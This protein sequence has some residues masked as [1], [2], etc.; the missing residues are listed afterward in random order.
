MSQINTNAID[1]DYPIPGQNNNS[2]GF[3]TNFTNIKTN[4]DTAGNEITDLQNKAVLKA[5]L[6]NLPLNNDMANTL[7]SNASVRS[8]RATTFNLG[9][10]ISGTVR[11][12][13]SLGDVQ[14]GTIVGNTTFNFG[15]WAPSGTEQKITLTINAANSNVAGNSIITF[16]PNVIYNN[17]NY[18]LTLVENFSST[19]NI[20]FPNDV[21]QLNFELR[22]TD[23][24]NTIYITPLNRSY[25]ASQLIQRTPPPTGQPGDTAGTV[26]FDANYVYVCTD[27]YNSI[28]NTVYIL[29]TYSSSNKV[30]IDNTTKVTSNDPIILSAN[31][32]G[33]VANTIYYVVGI[34]DP[35]APGNISVSATRTGGVAGANVA[36]STASGNIV[37]ISYNGTDI[38]KRISLTTW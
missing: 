17:N 35:G 5:A 20:S 15:S 21:T 7:V 8:F 9:N 34:A 31:I 1:T 23:C 3:R 24:G 18:G 36:L 10:S 29:N 16:S 33:L 22:T 28:A 30:Q 11:V 13:A 37:S 26:S 6:N 25:R 38:W 19:S 2:Q 14:S 32:G 27:T 4:L 12:D